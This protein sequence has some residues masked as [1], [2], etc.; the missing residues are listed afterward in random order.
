M[1]SLKILWSRIAVVYLVIL[2]CQVHAQTESVDWINKRAHELQSDS[3]STDQDLRFLS[4]TLKGKTI[5]GLGEASHGTQEFYYQ[6]R[7][8]IQYLVSQDQYRLIAL[9]SPAS[10]IEPINQYLQTGNG[11]LKSLLK[12][13]GLYNADEIYKLCRWLKS[14]NESR[15]PNDKVKMI[16][17]DDEEFWSDPFTRDEKMASNFIRAHEQGTPKSILWSQNLHLA[18]DTTMA[19]YKAMGFY[20]KKHFGEQYY[21]IGLDTYSGSVSVLNHG[22]FESHDFVGTDST[23]SALFSKANFEAFFVD[24]HAV[25]NPLLNTKNSITNIY[26]NWQEPKPLPIVAGIDFDG[27]LFIRNTTASKATGAN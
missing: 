14:F 27:L 9:E 3:T 1:H 11:N 21:A 4:S 22:Q 24:F 23:F 18:K 15:S 25:P 10:Y 16:G 5:L 12:I 8:I 2:P 7:R 19:Q 20:L 17:F 6:K 13:M 26:S